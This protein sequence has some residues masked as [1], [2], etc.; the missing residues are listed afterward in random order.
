VP[1]DCGQPCSFA[2]G[3]EDQGKEGAERAAEH[4]HDR[5]AGRRRRIP[6]SG[7]PHCITD[8]NADD[9]RY[10]RN[11]VLGQVAGQAPENRDSQGD[12]GAASHG[13]ARAVMAGR[14]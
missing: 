9:E 8:G 13:T 14:R 12:T 11:L 2:Q 5:R 4:G 7:P 10:Q 6:A 3:R 1:Q